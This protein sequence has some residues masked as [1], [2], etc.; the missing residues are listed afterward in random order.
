M[1]R[2]FRKACGFGVAAPGASCCDEKKKDFVSCGLR[3]FF[4]AVTRGIETEFSKIAS[5]AAAKS[6]NG[7]DFSRFAALAFDTKI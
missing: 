1:S 6:G 4:G 2:F 3:R 7:F 5:L